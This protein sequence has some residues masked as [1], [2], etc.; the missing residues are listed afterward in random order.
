[1]KTCNKCNTENS[2]LAKFCKKCGQS[3]THSTCSYCHTDNDA[4]AIFCQECGKSLV[5]LSKSENIVAASRHIAS[6]GKKPSGNFSN[7]TPDN[8][9]PRNN[10]DIKSI[11]EN[12]PE[13]IT[14]TNLADQKQTKQSVVPALIFGATISILLYLLNISYYGH[15]EWLSLPVN[16][17]I[18]GLIYLGLAAL[19]RRL[20]RK[21]AQ[22]QTETHT[23]EKSADAKSPGYFSR[24]D[25]EMKIDTIEKTEIS[26]V[27]T[28]EHKVNVSTTN[29][30]EIAFS[31]RRNFH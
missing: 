7:S 29:E 23:Q 12:K 15:A 14:K 1:M 28:E 25:A 16:F 13:E 9:Q 19:W 27:A 22:T 18:Y 4:D 20:S 24:L 8:I 3:L 5:D 30:D 17:A 11:S 26:Q 10:P 2:D 31:S 21:K 6:S